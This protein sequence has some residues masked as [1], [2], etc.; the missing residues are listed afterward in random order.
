[1]AAIERSDRRAAPHSTEYAGSDRSITM[2]GRFSVTD[3]GDHEVSPR[4]ACA[5]SHGQSHWAPVSSAASPSSAHVTDTR[6]DRPTPAC[7]SG[8]KVRRD[9]CQGRGRGLNVRPCISPTHHRSCGWMSIGLEL[10]LDVAKAAGS[11]TSV[12][13]RNLF[14]VPSDDHQQA[15]PLRTALPFVARG[16]GRRCAMLGSESGGTVGRR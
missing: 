6:R 8:T 16:R 12:Q 14:P 4:G 15:G 3:H 7:V 11:S 9:A 1:M 10:L 2:L 13:Q 5:C